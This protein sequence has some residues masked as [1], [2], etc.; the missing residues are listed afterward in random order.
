MA[1]TRYLFDQHGDVV[2]H[3]VVD[4]DYG[5][6]RLETAEDAT[7]ILDEN[8]RRYN[9]G[10]DGYGASRE[11]HEVADIPY[12]VA[13]KWLTDY[14]IDIWNPDHRLGVNRLLNSNEW[15]YLRTGRG[16]LRV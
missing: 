9:D 6:F 5:Y 16:V 11:W 13:L 4:D 15:L 12:T 2:R 10:T 1:E 14:G 3:L 8:K 7:P